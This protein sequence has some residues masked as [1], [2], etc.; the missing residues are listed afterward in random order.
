MFDAHQST[1]QARPH[2]AARKILSMQRNDILA[3]E[4]TEGDR[5]LVRVVKFSEKQFAVAPPHEGGSLKA[6]D[7][8]ADDPFRYLYP[9]PNT[10]KG[11]RARQVRIDELGRVLDPGFPARKTV[12]RTRPR[13][14]PVD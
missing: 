3:I 11:W 8:D 9:S 6:R 5:E 13:T 14:A 1:E 10:L 12:R 4:R 7:G 2:P